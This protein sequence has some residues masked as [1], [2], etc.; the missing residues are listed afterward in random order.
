M[1]SRLSVLALGATPEQRAPFAEQL[2]LSL[3]ASGCIEID[4]MGRTSTPGVYAA[5]DAAHTAATPIPLSSV[6]AAAAAG[7]NAAMAVDTALLTA[8]HGLLPPGAPQAA[9]AVSGG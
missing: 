1:A 7:K 9:G 4:P 8:D 2:G 3:L 5:G 6:V